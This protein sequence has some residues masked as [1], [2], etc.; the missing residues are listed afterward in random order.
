MISIEQQN[1]LFMSISKRM[2]RKIT[3]YAIGGTAMMFHG[4]KDATLD[5]DLVFMSHSD[6]A[7]FEEAAVSL[8]YVKMDSIDVY[9]DRSNK[10]EMVKLGESR[11]DLFLPKVMNTIFSEEMVKRAANSHAFSDKL[12]I[13]IADPGDILIMK[14]ATERIKDRDDVKRMSEITSLNWDAI[15]SEAKNQI[16]LGNSVMA[17]ELGCFLEEMNNKLGM[18]VPKKVLDE[19]FGVVEKQSREKRKKA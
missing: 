19:L 6:R 15:V 1:N 18:D 3:A 11:L 2:K 8:G 7:I 14:C 10:P 9:G 13:K 4:L 16:A 12:T 5:I 17:M